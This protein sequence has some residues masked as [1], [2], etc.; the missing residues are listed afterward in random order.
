MVRGKPRVPRMTNLSN[1]W[2]PDELVDVSPN[3]FLDLDSR[4]RYFSELVSNDGQGV[5]AVETTLGVG[6]RF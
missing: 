2:P 1:S 5:N 6:W 4:Y 3:L